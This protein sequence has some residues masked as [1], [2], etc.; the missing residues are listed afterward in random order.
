M[1]ILRYLLIASIALLIGACN[2]NHTS[3]GHSHDVIG[4][5]GHT[6]DHEHEEVT[7]SYTLFSGDL[8]LFVEF[9]PLVAGQIT[10]FAVHLTNLVNH[11]P[12][13]HG[14]L[15]VSIIK[16][17]RGIRH[18]VNAPSSP[19]IFR[20]A[21]QPNEAG[22]YQMLFELSGGDVN[23]I[24]EIPDI[25]VFENAHD[26]AHAVAVDEA[27]DAVIFTKEQAWKTEFETQTIQP[28][29]FYSVI[30][31]SARVKT[32][33]QSEITINAQA[34]G[35]VNLYAVL[36]QTVRKG[37]LLAIVAGSGIDNN[38]NLM[39]DESRIAFERRKADYVR[40]RPLAESQAISQKDFLEIEAR[41]RQ[42]SLRYNQIANMV[43][44][45]G[46]KIVSPIDGFVGN[47]RAVNGSFVENGTPVITIKNDSQ[48]LIE[49]FVNKSD[50][51]RVSEIFD[52]NFSLPGDKSTIALND[53]NGRLI[54]N[55]PFVNENTTR[56]PV[57]FSGKNNGMLMPG[58]FLEAYLKTGRKESAMVV[59]LSSIVEQQGLYYIFV[60]IGGESFEKRQVKLAHN[61]GV[62]TEIESGLMPG[63]RIVTKGAV[64]VMLASLAGSL[65]LHGHTH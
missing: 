50:F 52:A 23:T 3:H 63:E 39:L 60:Q 59:P 22:T 56:I 21:L 64:Q 49:A 18:R 31:T 11:D 19:G 33:P 55:N 40:S 54:A 34:S 58:M 46:L 5:H 26:A 8:E 53:L 6:D 62:L 51:R 10:T 27:A 38:I 13:R 16:N 25:I 24:F 1:I 28:S 35:T 44:H 45:K 37:E 43:S 15:T 14:Q 32:T 42:D 47:I 29:L 61:D 65:P 7:M 20:P 9:Q 41:Y 36:G 4:G 48:V 57:T 12:V 17:N 30:R 2:Q